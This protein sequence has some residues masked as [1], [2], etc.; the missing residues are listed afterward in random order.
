MQL[1]YLKS[2]SMP[3]NLN[4]RKSREQRYRERV[5][6]LDDTQVI[7]LYLDLSGKVEILE[8]LIKEFDRAFTS[9]PLPRLYLPNYRN[10]DSNFEADETEAFKLTQKIHVWLSVLEE[11]ILARNLSTDELTYTTPAK[12]RMY[13]N[14]IDFGPFRVAL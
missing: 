13:G 11:E 1:F 14:R 6:M 7:R 5:E 9:H 8:H 10:L 3:F 2:T 12:P 4:F